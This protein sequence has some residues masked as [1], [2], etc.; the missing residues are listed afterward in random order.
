MNPWST[1][2]SWLI[3]YAL[4]LWSQAGF[5]QSLSLFYDRLTLEGTPIRDAPR[6]LMV[7]ARQI[8][9]YATAKRHNWM[10]NPADLIARAAESMVRHYYEVDGQ[11]GWAMSVDSS[12]RVVDSRRD[13]YAHSFVLFGLAAA[14]Q[15]TGDDQYLDL[16]D[17]TLVFLDSMMSHQGGGYV[18]ALPS[19]PSSEL[20]ANPH[21]HLLEALLALYA[22][23]PKNEYSERAE[24]IVALFETRF[25]QPSAGILC[26]HFTSSWLPVGGDRGRL[27]EP[28][29]HYEWIWLLDRYSHLLGRML[30]PCTDSLRR[31]ALKYGR[32][33]GGLLW[34]QVRDDG[35][36][37]NSS[38]RLWPHTE[39]LKA[40]LSARC[41]DGYASAGVWLDHLYQ[42]FLKLAFAGG[43]HDLF[44]VDGRLLVDYMP[45]SS[46]Y[47]IVCA[48][49]EYESQTGVEGIHAED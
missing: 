1:A 3:D 23:A 28:G 18:T 14:F 29:H 11:P 43:W 9:S 46:L 17:H 35:V 45:A 39:V 5:D 8:Y 34:S 33:N 24:E 30:P 10:G 26:E 48:F 42:R 7:Q 13:F 31:T 37:I 2:R 6:R 44:D 47:H 20:Q 41:G 49:S 22:V 21:M 16:A 25:F 36:V 4:P 32:S 12:G 19:L 40:E 38:F 15:S 27:F